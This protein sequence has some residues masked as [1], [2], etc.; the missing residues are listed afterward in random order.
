[1]DFDRIYLLLQ[2]VQL[3]LGHPNLKPIT[4]AAAE[5]LAL[6]ASGVIVEEPSNADE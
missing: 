6:H 5:E 2:V 3:S 1:M 4:D